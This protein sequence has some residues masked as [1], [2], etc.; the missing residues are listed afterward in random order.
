MKLRVG[1]FNAENLFTRFK[2][3]SNLSSRE[4]ERLTERGWELEKTLFEPFDP[5]ERKITA[6]AIEGINADILGLQEVESLP[7]LKRFNDQFLKKLGY[8]YQMLIDGNDARG[9]DVALL[10]RY[11]F[12]YVQSYQFDTAPDGKKIFSR[13]CLE[14]GVKVA[15]NRVLPVFVNHFKS[16][17]GGR[18]KTTPQRKAQATRVHEILMSRFNGRPEAA[19]WIVMGDLNDYQPSEGLAPLLNRPYLENVLL[20]LPESERWTHYYAAEDEYHQLDYLLLS[21]KLAAANKGL[22]YVERRGAT[23]RAE[24]V[25]IDRFPN[26]DLERKASDHCPQVFEFDF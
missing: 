17:S 11:P 14:V 4:V 19:E 26:V 5:I 2:F 24:R 6:D 15:P 18:G 12:A 7:T 8:K 25:T 13:D 1:T 9:I 10:S 23:T 21:K 16:M 20:R 3:D 22:P